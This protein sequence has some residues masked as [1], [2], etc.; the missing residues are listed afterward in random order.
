MADRV[1]RKLAR[2]ASGAASIVLAA[3]CAACSA[4]SD[5]AGFSIVTQDKY[6]FSTCQE[7]IAART[8]QR[9][10][11]K[12][13]T[14]LVEKAE[15]APGGFIVAAGTYRSELVQARAFAAAADRAAKLKGC[16]TAKK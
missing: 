12:E 9:A 10:R 16:D 2:L 5:P 7:I 8:A 1:L 3:L 6:D 14:E 15:S 11:Q 13:L 4:V